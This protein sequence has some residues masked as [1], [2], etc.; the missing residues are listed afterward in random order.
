MKK[1]SEKPGVGQS[2][3]FQRVIEQAL[4]FANIPRPL[5]IRGER[6]TGK[7]LLA[8]FLHES[9]GRKTSP[10]IAF[11]CAALHE[12]LFLSEM[13]GHEKGAFTGAVSARAGKL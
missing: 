3:I 6:G 1:Q 5:L 8:R 4:T 11:N 10:F 12:E 9:S 7:E 2:Q 13:F